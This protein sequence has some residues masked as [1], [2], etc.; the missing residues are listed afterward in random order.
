MMSG[1]S[2][3]TSIFAALLGKLVSSERPHG[4]WKSARKEKCKKKLK[5][6]LN[7]FSVAEK[8]ELHTVKKWVQNILW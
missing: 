8:F 2:H 6:K 7:I 1:W 3:T 5:K 4:K